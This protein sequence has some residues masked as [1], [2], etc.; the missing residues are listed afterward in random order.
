MSV[1]RKTVK[2]VAELA[3][4]DLTEREIARFSRDLDEVLSAFRTLQRTPTRG[5]KPAFQ[6]VEA[7]NV[8]RE[9][10]VEPSIPRKRLLRNLRNR[11]DGYIK[12]PRVV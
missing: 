10:R 11:E 9:D 7:R 8:L 1:D 12:G 5:V 4:L 6:P 2:R 3:R